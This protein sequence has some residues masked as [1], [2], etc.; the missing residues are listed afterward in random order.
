MFA[1]NVSS[2]E[3]IP[4]AEGVKKNTSLHNFICN[5]NRI[6]KKGVEAFAEAIK[7]HHSLTN[8]SLIDGNL[9]AKLHPVLEVF[10]NNMCPKIVSLDISK[11]QMSSTSGVDLIGE[12]VKFNTT[13][14]NLNLS[15]NHIDLEETT[16]LFNG[17]TSNTSLT[18]LNISGSNLCQPE[19]GRAI[20]E[21]LKTNTSLYD[22][23]LSKCRLDNMQSCNYIFESLKTNKTLISLN[24]YHNGIKKYSLVKLNESMVE[25]TSIQCLDLGDNFLTTENVLLLTDMIE[26]NST[27]KELDLRN[28]TLV[29]N[30]NTSRIVEAIIKNKSIVKLNLDDNKFSDSSFDDFIKLIGVKK[31]TMNFCVERNKFSEN[32][33]KI[34]KNK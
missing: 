23:N 12:M 32:K 27:L 3:F 28:N 14:R 6:G 25:N 20:G 26:K 17:L 22:L 9:R 19:T 21:Y 33:M 1:N 15:G 29:S 16:L 4:I 18:S 7:F 5:Y 8:V 11:N 34:L 13:L 2:F 30:E 10:K 24:L 31:D